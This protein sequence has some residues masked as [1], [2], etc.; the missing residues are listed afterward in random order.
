MFFRY[1]GSISRDEEEARL[2]QAA[3]GLP[4]DTAIFLV[5]AK[6]GSDRVSH[7][8]VLEHVLQI[9]SIARILSHNLLPRLLYPSLQD[10]VLTWM[11]T[12][13]QLIT[14]FLIKM[15]RDGINVEAV[16]SV[17]LRP[18]YVTT[19]PSSSLRQFGGGNDVTFFLDAKT[20]KKTRYFRGINQLVDHFMVCVGRCKHD[21]RLQIVCTATF[22][23]C[24]R[25]HLLPTSPTSHS[26]RTKVSLV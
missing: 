16:Y 17:T 12:G 6:T 19:N 13:P 4:S 11:Q 22:L 5:R 23:P 21:T 7:T 18:I 10:Y 15:V 1:H 8:P 20:E 9:I 25:F 2:V 3:Q 14:R 26:N 24:L